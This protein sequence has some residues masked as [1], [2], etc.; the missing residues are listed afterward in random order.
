M[1]HTRYLHQLLTGLLVLSLTGCSV[2][3]FAVNK[4]GNALAESGTTYSSDN[5]PDLVEGAIP[6]S[7]KLIESLLAA[8]PNHRGM[9]FAA[10]SGFT[11]YAYAFVQQRADSL[12]DHNLAAAAETRTRARKLYIRARDYGLRGLETRHRAFRE[13]LMR[14]PRAAVRATTVKDVALLYWTAAAWGA[15]IAISKEFPEIVADQTQM[16]ALIDRALELDEQFD[17]GAIHG[18]LISYEPSRQGVPGDPYER[19]RK[20]FERVVSLTNGQLAS[21]YVS[22]AEAVSVNTQNREEFE[23]LLKKAIAINP[24]T[25]PEWRLSTL[26][27]QRRA[28]WL[29][30]RTDDLFLDAPK[31]PAGGR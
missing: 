18:L 11:Q 23:A 24:D 1:P 16:E 9:L 7:L 28:R 3:R 27:M 25:R 17:F 4:R 5:D 2:K 12:E 14:D 30:G 6:F 13:G 15:A 20:H 10:A 29:L 8:S 21:P 31:S 19:S 26:I 22:L